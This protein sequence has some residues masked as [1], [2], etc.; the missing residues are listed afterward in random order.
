MNITD[1]DGRMPYT[2]DDKYNSGRSERAHIKIF[3]K[4]AWKAAAEMYKVNPVDPSGDD[5]AKDAAWNYIKEKR[6][7]YVPS[8]A[9]IPARYSLTTVNV[10][11]IYNEAKLLYPEYKSKKTL[12]MDALQKALASQPPS[13]SS[14]DTAK[15]GEY[16]AL[17]A[18][19]AHDYQNIQAGV[20]HFNASRVISKL[21]ESMDEGV[22]GK[23]S[24]S[25]TQGADVISEIKNLDGYSYQQVA[26]KL[27]VAIAATQKKEAKALYRGIDKVEM[28]K[29]LA[30]A[31]NNGSYVP[32]RFTAFSGTEAV[33]G[34]FGGAGIIELAAGAYG[35]ARVGLWYSGVHE[36][37]ILFDRKAAFEVKAVNKNR[38]QVR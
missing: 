10:Q 21:K 25:K 19:W 29:W 32:K 31:Q 23:H 33:A 18:V 6:E 37:E 28:N 20:G 11:E 3:D 1:T 26:E 15:Q 9:S 22:V 24:W 17:F 13:A 38:I 35:G 27:D 7:E 8:D 4:I 34:T 12:K 14:I 5:A 2:F 30:A 16:K 36:N